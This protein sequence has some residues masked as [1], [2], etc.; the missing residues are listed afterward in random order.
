METT[1][2]GYIGILGTILG[3][4]W[5]NGYGSSP[6]FLQDIWVILIL[7]GYCRPQYRRRVTP[8]LG[9]GYGHGCGMVW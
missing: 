5:D 1:I 2:M 4:Y 3:F 9:H 6:C 8:P 7:G